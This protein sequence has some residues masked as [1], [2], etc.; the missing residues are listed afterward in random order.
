M[1]VVLV[2]NKVDLEDEREVSCDEGQALA[3]DWGCPFMEASA[4]S[5]TMVDQLFTE[6][7][8]QMDSSSLPDRDKPCCSACSLQ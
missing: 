7:V 1:P 4:K 5:K 3:E 6:I 8:R 2:G